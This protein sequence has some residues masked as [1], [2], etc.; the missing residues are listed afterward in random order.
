[1]NDTDFSYITGFMNKKFN[2]FDVPF[3]V[4]LLRK[5]EQTVVI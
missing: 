1:M 3:W 4:G 5:N 2:L